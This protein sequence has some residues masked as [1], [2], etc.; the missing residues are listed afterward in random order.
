M[1]TYD[2][3]DWSVLIGYDLE[4]RACTLVIN[5]VA[6][7][8]LSGELVETISADIEVND[9]QI[10]KGSEIV[11]WDREALKSIIK[12]QLDEQLIFKFLMLHIFGTQR[13]IQD[14]ITMAG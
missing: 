4:K 9:H 2:E 10:T 8:D 12:H 5:G 14:F 11:P 6:F 7:D 13:V 3:L 1:V